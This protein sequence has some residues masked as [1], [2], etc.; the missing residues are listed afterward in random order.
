MGRMK[1][2][3]D[4]K[5]RGQAA[6]DVAARFLQSQGYRIV[7]RNWRTRYGELD[8]IAEDRAALVFV[9]VRS[10]LSDDPT[11]PQETITSKK[12]RQVSQSALAYV[13]QHNIQDRPCRFDV[14]EVFLNHDGK[15]VRV[16]LLKNAFELPGARW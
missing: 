1:K 13:S 15:P 5:Q 10:K 3:D 11:T 9:E 7:A 4:R 2:A 12:Q 16:N 14:V 6:E 8:I